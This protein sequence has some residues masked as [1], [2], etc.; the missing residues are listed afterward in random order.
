[1][2]R[3]DLHRDVRLLPVRCVPPTNPLTLIHS[4]PQPHPSP[5]PLTLTPT[6][7]L[8]LNLPIPRGRQTHSGGG[9]LAQ[10]VY[11]RGGT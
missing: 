11:L 8:T 1:M 2:Q 6:L 4:Q 3:H 7:T 9:L 10:A 5:N